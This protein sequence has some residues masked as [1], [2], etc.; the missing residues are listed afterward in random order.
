MNKDGSSEDIA[1]TWMRTCSVRGQIEGAARLAGRVV[2]DCIWSHLRQ[3][4]NLLAQ[5]LQCTGRSIRQNG[6]SRPARRSSLDRAQVWRYSR[7]L[8]TVDWAEQ[9]MSQSCI[10][11]SLAPCS[12]RRCYMTMPDLSTMWHSPDA[13]SSVHLVTDCLR[14][15]WW[16]CSWICNVYPFKLWTVWLWGVLTVVVWHAQLLRATMTSAGCVVLAAD[17][18]T[19][20]QLNRPP[21][22]L[23]PVLFHGACGRGEAVWV[24]CSCPCRMGL[25]WLALA[26]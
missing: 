20:R 15:P 5:D 1:E 19:L 14:S 23:P 10:L 13:S 11:G 9:I 7:G 3:A 6:A 24:A 18:G 8:E 12:C 4:S 21:A 22:M 17:T 25:V 26:H 16:P 2:V